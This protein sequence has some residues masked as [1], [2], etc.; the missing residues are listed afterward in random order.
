MS[1]STTKHEP[2]P[3]WLV[4]LTL[5]ATAG[6]G[7]LWWL[8]RRPVRYLTTEDLPPTVANDIEVVRKLNEQERN[9]VKTAFLSGDDFKWLVAGKDYKT[10]LNEKQHREAVFGFIEYFIAFCERYGHILVCRDM[11][12]ILLGA[13]GFIPPYKNE[14]M[15]ILHF[16][17]TVI[18]LGKPAAINM[19]EGP[20]A[21]CKA[22]S[23]VT[24]EH[25]ELMNGIPHWY[26]LVIGVSPEAQGK[27]VGRKLI[28][29]AIAIAGD[30]PMYLDCH[31]GNVPFY[32]KLGFSA[33]K[34]YDIIPEK[35]EDT[36][37]FQMNG[38]IRGM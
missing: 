15:Y 14:R 7:A 18:P 17:R 3:I 38:M 2:V 36:S 23:R 31:N 22:F 16:Y 24:E 33:G 13:V 19:C 28:E 8:F 12:G 26:I 37:S 1:K 32:E 4:S 20:A 35:I 11:D 29:A 30:M 34:R 6:A 10:N 27:G 21:R 25:K 9:T 5:I